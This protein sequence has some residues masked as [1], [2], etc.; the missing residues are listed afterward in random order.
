MLCHSCHT[1]VEKLVLPS[2]IEI[3]PIMC[4]NKMATVLKSNPRCHNTEQR[5]IQGISNDLINQVVEKIITF[6]EF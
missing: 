6:K 4:D 1:V 3:V 2:D 5:R